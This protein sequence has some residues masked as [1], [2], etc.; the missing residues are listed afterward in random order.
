MLSCMLKVVIDKVF[1]FT[2]TFEGHLSPTRKTGSGGK[3]DINYDMTSRLA[4]FTIK[5]D[6]ARQS[7]HGKYTH[8]H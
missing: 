6:S 3:F 7:E 2:V 5:V 8:V 1:N 4:T